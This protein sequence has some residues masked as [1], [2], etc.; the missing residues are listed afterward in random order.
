M[1][2]NWTL[3]D[4]SSSTKLSKLSNIEIDGGFSFHIL[5]GP[6]NN[7]GAKYFHLFLKRNKEISLDP[8]IFGLYNSGK[9]PGQNWLEVIHFNQIIEFSKEQSLDI[10][11]Q[12]ELE[13]FQHLGKI[14]PPGG[15]MMIEYESE[16]RRLTARSLL[17]G[18]PPDATP[19]GRLLYISGCGYSIKNWYI[20]EGGKEGLRKLQ[21]FKPLDRKHQISSAKKQIDILN[22][23]IASEEDI[24]W[25]IR[26]YTKPIAEQ[27]HMYLS[28]IIKK[29]K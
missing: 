21:G 12:A 6:T 2:K 1:K 11:E 15:H 19:I 3:I 23:Y 29:E 27:A 20:P 25:D 7:V 14:L 22:N 18:V 9:Y 10:S 24:E 13:I 16:Y 5:D 26:G 4:P 28:D 17:V 8:I